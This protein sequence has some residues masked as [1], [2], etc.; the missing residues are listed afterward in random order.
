MRLAPIPLF[1]ASNPRQAIDYSG[2]SSRTTHGTKAAVDA[3]RYFAGLL[4]GA[5]R[6]KPKPELLSQ[7]FYPSDD[8]EFWND[9]GLDS[10]IAAIAAG[11][12]KKKDPPIIVNPV[13]LAPH[14]LTR[15]DNRMGEVCRSPCR[16][17]G[18]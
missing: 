3:C 10:K 12:F 1:F 13:N 17:P 8:P 4:V 18:G 6:G 5:L 15:T 7:Y 9:N 11:S 2:E 14:L 16:R